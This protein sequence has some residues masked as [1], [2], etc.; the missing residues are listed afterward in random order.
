MTDDPRS[1]LWAL[2][3]GY[4]ITQAIGVAVRLGI[5]DLVTERP[6]S[7]AELASTAG[8]DPDSVRRLLR[9]L[10]SL[11][12]FAERNGVIAHT[13]MSQLLCSDVPGSM[14]AQSELFSGVNYLTWA[15]APETFRTGEPA[16]PRA[17]GSPFFEW[18][19]D[20]PDESALFN[21]SMAGGAAVRRQQLLARDWSGVSTIVDVGGG[22]GAT[23]VPLLQ[24]H[25]TLTGIVFDLPQ[26]GPDATRTITE[27]GLGDRCSFAAGSFF[28]EVPAGADV[29]VLS[30]ILHDWD[31]EP[32]G[33]VLRAVRSAMT[34]TS[35]LVLLESVIA[36]GDEPDPAKILDLHMLVA[37]GGRERAEDEW[38]NLLSGNG[39]AMAHAR[40]GLIE[41]VTGRVRTD[42]G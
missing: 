17:H 25:P 37:L 36:P 6:R 23:L 21:A 39:F 11:G 33:T 12:V 19:G 32:A 41:A 42:G 24:A 34:P 13:E 31:D 4:M 5:P 20:H 2:A 18:L 8:A 30:K 16:F 22:N 26:V 35:R 28:E 14:A 7:S 29:Y 15:D 10:A 40:S 3:S 27:A 9:A 1:R 38:R